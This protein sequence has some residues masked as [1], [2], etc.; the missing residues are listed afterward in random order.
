M[1]N[2]CVIFSYQFIWIPVIMAWRVKIAF[3]KKLRADEM[4]GMLLQLFQ[5]LLSSYLLSKNKD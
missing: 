1:I 5:N 3:K 2:I 4:W